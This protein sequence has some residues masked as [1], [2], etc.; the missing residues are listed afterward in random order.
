MSRCWSF[1]ILIES[2]CDGYAIVSVEE[3]D[4][5]GRELASYQQMV[6]ITASPGTSQNWSWSADARIAENIDHIDVTEAVCAGEM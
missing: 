6:G 4:K 5:S 2:E 1:D 3:F